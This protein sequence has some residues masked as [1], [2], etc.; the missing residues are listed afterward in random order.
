MYIILSFPAG[1]L[2]GVFFFGGLWWTV[3][4]LSTIRSPAIL[5]IVSFLVRTAVVMAGF[6]VLLMQGLP[7]LFIALGGYFVA[8]MWC[9]HTF[10]PQETAAV[11]QGSKS[12]G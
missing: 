2:L 7:H 1:L 3:M 10:K 5:F 8:R 12:K 4:K 11:R 9:I 6:Y